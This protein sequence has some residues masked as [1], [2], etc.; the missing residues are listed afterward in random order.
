MHS[1]NTDKTSQHGTLVFFPSQ[2]P[3]SSLYFNFLALCYSTL[4]KPCGQDNVE[5]RKGW[6]AIYN[7]KQGNYP[8]NI[9]PSANDSFVKREILFWGTRE[10][11]LLCD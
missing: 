6:K 8:P 5:A 1:S 4:E 7:T 3:K 2:P 11:I 10:E 9:M